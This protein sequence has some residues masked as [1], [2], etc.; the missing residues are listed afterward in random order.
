MATTQLDYFR[1]NGNTRYTAKVECAHLKTGIFD[2]STVEASMRRSEWRQGT[3]AWNP[4]TWFAGGRW[5]QTG[6]AAIIQSIEFLDA[7]GLDILYHIQAN[8]THYSGLSACWAIFMSGFVGKAGKIS[9]LGNDARRVKKVK[10]K[11][12]IPADP[13]RAAQTRE[14]SVP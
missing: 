9:D 8:C 1:Y 6:D 2:R 14:L 4:T 10:M 7:S 5:V 13:Q 12:T 11:F 3:Q